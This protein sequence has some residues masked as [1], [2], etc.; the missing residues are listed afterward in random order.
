MT[1]RPGLGAPAATSPPPP[2]LPP[3]ARCGTRCRSPGTRWTEGRCSDAGQTL[4]LRPSKTPPACRGAAV[5]PRVHVPGKARGRH[6]LPELLAG[7]QDLGHVLQL[8]RFL[9]HAAHTL[10]H[11]AGL[12]APHRRVRG[13]RGPA[14]RPRWQLSEPPPARPPR[15]QSSSP[16]VGG[17]RQP[18]PAASAHLSG[19]GHFSPRQA[20]IPPT[21]SRVI[22][23]QA[24]GETHGCSRS[25]ARRGSSVP[26]RLSHGRVGAASP[27]GKGPAPRR[28][29]PAK[30]LPPARLPAGP[31]AVRT[32][33]PLLSLPASGRGGQ[34]AHGGAQRSPLLTPFPWVRSPRNLTPTRD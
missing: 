18:A 7:E 1:Y 19:A 16:R 15:L 28:E 17:Q 2:L 21:A 10:L 12:R 3:P 8:R 34:K 29:L 33:P 6:R 27:R 4:A 26:P 23:S 30:Q 25:Q 11:A 24:G 9:L 32:T 20:R 31:A 22:V 5:G 13:D 14:A